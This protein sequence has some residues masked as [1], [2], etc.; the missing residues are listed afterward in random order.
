MNWLVWVWFAISIGSMFYVLV[1][2]NQGK[3]MAPRE[4]GFFFL[5]MF[6]MGVPF[7]YSVAS[8]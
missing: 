3:G 4:I 5:G 8:N 2:V 7:L 1:Q 6:I